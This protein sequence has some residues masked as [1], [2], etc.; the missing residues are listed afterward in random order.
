M[1]A[2][3]NLFMRK[4]MITILKRGRLYVL[5]MLCVGCATNKKID[6]PVDQVN[7]YM[8]NISH[9]LVPTYPTIH[10]PNSMLRVYPERQDFTTDQLYGLPMIVTSH[11]GRSA[12]NLSPLDRTAKTQFNNV[13]AL[14]YD[15]EVIKPYL[16]TS[17]LQNGD[18]DVKYAPS[19]QSALY[20]IRFRE[21]YAPSLILN[22]QSGTI[23]VSGNKIKASQNLDNKTIVYLYAEVDQQPIKIGTLNGEGKLDDQMTSKSGDQVAAILHFE[24]GLELLK[25]RYGISFI[26]EEQAELNLRREIK[27]YDLEVLA[28][29]GRD[30][31]NNALGKIQVKGLSPDDEALFY[32]SAYRCYERPVNITEDGRYFSA[33]D[34][35]VHAAER[36]FY[37]DD[38]IWDTYRATHPLRL[39]IDQDVESDMI[40]SFV[41]MAEQMDQFW[42]PTFPE[43]TGDSRRM[44]SNHGVA[45]IADAYSKGLR[46]FD[47]E[48]A[49][50]SAKGAIEDKTLAPWSAQPAGWLD[51]FYKTH[52]YIP[53]LKP[54][55]EET[56][57]EVH[58]FEKR[59]PIAVTLGTSYD[60]WCLAQLAMQLGKKEDHEKYSKR[61]LNY[62]N[63]F[64]AKT[65]F[66]HPKDKD[67]KFIEPFDYRYDGGQGAREYYGENNGWVYRWDV[68]HHIADLID[69]MGGRNKFIEN[70]DQTFREPLG[71]SKFEFYSQLPDHTGNVGQF[72]M[73]NEPSLHVPYLYNYVG[74]PWK[75]QKRIHQL[76]HQWFRN[77]LMG[78]PGD[79]DGG[80]M[81]A[82]V[83]FTMLGFYPVTP[84]MPIYVIGTPFFKEAQIT[85][86]GGKKLMIKA[87]NLS[88]QHKYIQSAK[89]NGKEWNKAWF[90]HDD[91][92]N[93]GLIEFVM[94]QYPNK[95]W[96]AKM[97]DAPPSFKY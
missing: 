16:Y 34:G 20:E 95:E 30:I 10:L 58:H 36:P 21:R 76:V 96:G 32:S 71:K 75:S 65:G 89:I 66:F 56:V 54:G 81:S 40:Q 97:E 27:D 77:D 28:N 59:Q 33:F 87:E 91:I 9:L 7:P 29:K 17:N 52:G 4:Y 1:Y 41:R 84:G 8:G 57:P 62:R 73:A 80:G 25:I 90:A 86:S 15:N 24:P 39:L 92:V 74:Q 45:T 63:V 23:S 93:G 49:Y 70:L 46:S 67:G 47:V 60:E 69:L 6:S 64:N 61:A 44:N 37:T 43:I 19:H 18:M 31:W 85:L 3:R 51:D 72:S 13:Y 14:D 88:K 22:T 2:L 35:Q 42:L 55:E 83:V 79:E 26:S 12:F 5:T 94:G 78:M 11:R 53:A 82:F 48:K 68:P 50:Q 38:W